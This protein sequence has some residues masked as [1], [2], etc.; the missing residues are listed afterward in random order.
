MFIWSSYGLAKENA[1]FDAQLA[2]ID[3]SLSGPLAAQQWDD[4]PVNRDRRSSDGAGNHFQHHA[5][6][7]RAA[8]EIMQLARKNNANYSPMLIQVNINCFTESHYPLV[9]D[10]RL[11]FRAPYL[12]LYLA[13]EGL[14]AA[15]VLMLNKNRTKRSLGFT[16]PREYSAP[17]VLNDDTGLG[18]HDP[19]AL[20]GVVQYFGASTRPSAILATTPEEAEVARRWF[21]ERGIR[22]RT[23]S[24]LSLKNKEGI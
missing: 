8:Q 21:N 9:F 24:L 4:G 1:R 16:G 19:R 7:F 5:Q 11:N 10:N 12:G 14:D 20:F 17:M 6:Y 18:Y 23:I 15:W 22:Y 2:T 3:P 13:N